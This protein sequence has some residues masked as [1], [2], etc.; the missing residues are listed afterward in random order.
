M[1]QISCFQG[2]EL[3]EFNVLLLG[4]SGSGK[5]RVV[6]EKTLGPTI[7][8]E[9]HL[10]KLNDAH[11]LNFYDTPG[12]L[13]LFKQCLNLDIIQS[14]DII[15]CFP[16]SEQYK[17]HIKELLQN[18]TKLFKQIPFYDIPGELE[19]KE[20]RNKIYLYILSQSKRKSKKPSYYQEIV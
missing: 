10:V 11:G 2:N 14:V 17:E 16:N 6:T 20:I 1:G 3:T 12:I 15:V 7:K 8:L 19:S 5:T 4:P 9:K 13:S 18:N